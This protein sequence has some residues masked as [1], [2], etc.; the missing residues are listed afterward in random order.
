M[1]VSANGKKSP[2]R[3]LKKAIWDVLDK[4][5]APSSFGVAEIKK[6]LGSKGWTH[7]VHYDTNSMVHAINDLVVEGCVVL[8]NKS[9]GKVKE[10]VWSYTNGQVSSALAP[11]QSKIDEIVEELSDEVVSRV[12]QRAKQKLGV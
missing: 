9:S 11:T 12:R 7:G 6:G 2:R 10:R 5:L 8:K 3:G 4:G 1:N